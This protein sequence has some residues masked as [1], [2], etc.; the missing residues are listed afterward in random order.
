MASKIKPVWTRPSIIECGA[1]VIEQEASALVALAGALDSRFEGAVNCIA[2]A[3]RQIV[4]TGLGKSGLIARK[5]ASTLAATNTPACFVHAA[6]A[7]HGDLGMMLPGDVLI[8]LSNSGATAELRPIIHRARQ[9]GV[10]VI[11]VGSRAESFLLTNAD[12]P[13][14]LPQVEEACPHGTAPTSSTTMMMALGD[15]L[16]VA[17]M[18]ARGTT[19]DDI[20]RLH[21]AGS[22]G[23]RLAPVE[24]LLRPRA[25]LP[26]V[27][28]D[29]SLRDAI[30]EMSSHGRGVV[31]V[32][33]EDNYL[34][35]VIT[36]GD[37]RRSIDQAT[38]A[39][40]ID[41]M[42]RDPLTVRADMT[43]EEAYHVMHEN[44]INVLVVVA[45]DNPR[46][47]IGIVHIHDLDLIA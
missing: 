28:L 14:L 4:V 12:Y 43:R 29:A 34:A 41:V 45:R 15:A 36:D 11:A 10:P 9:I 23:N 42:T 37:V 2:T 38:S 8:A 39:A 32:L 47:P 18:Q 40:C 6:E 13:L 24:T 46:K 26:H 16:A 30:L 19:L 22:I 21:P 33:D 5:I 25:R 7:G 20:A 3:K 27:G 1:A 44:R 17:V 35:G 31:C